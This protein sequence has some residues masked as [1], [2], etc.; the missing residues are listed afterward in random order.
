MFQNLEHQTEKQWHEFSQ[1]F[2]NKFALL[3]DE[4]NQSEDN[5]E[6]EN[7]PESEENEE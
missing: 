6:V 4:K 2:T 3:K 7:N 1:Q 5:S